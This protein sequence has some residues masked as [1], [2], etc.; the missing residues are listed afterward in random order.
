MEE[1]QISG[2]HHSPT[3]IPKEGDDQQEN[4]MKKPKLGP[5]TLATGVG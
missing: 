2:G 5:G 1:R 3:G 4:Q